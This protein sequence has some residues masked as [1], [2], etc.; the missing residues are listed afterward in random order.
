[1]HLPECM[2]LCMPAHACMDAC[3][4]HVCEYACLCHDLSLTHAQA[5][6]A[7]IQN[8]YWPYP[9]HPTLGPRH[10]TTIH[11][12]SLTSFLAPGWYDCHGGLLSGTA[13]IA[14][15]AKTSSRVATSTP[16]SGKHIPL[17]PPLPGHLRV[18]PGHA[19]YHVSAPLH[20]DTPNP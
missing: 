15:Q 8:C 7:S 2:H 16:V 11:R 20:P 17:P 13:K 10:L 19:W 6:V 18:L 3:R 14:R 12:S 4:Q 5:Q 1:M 9:R